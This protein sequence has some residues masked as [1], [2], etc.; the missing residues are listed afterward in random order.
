MRLPNTMIR[1]MN[2]NG[3]VRRSDLARSFCAWTASSRVTSTVP[4]TPVETIWPDVLYNGAS[5]AAI[6][7][8]ASSLPRNDATMSAWC[9][10]RLAS[11]AMSPRLQYDD[12]VTTPASRPRRWVSA[13]PAA[14]TAGAS[15]VPCFA[16]T[17][18]TK[19]DWPDDGNS[20]AMA[21]A[22]RLDSAPGSS[23][24]PVES[25]LCTPPPY[26]ANSGSAINATAITHHRRRITKIARRRTS[27]LCIRSVRA[28]DRSG[29]EIDFP[30]SAWKS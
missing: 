3:P 12:D 7:I 11:W 22:A 10:L 18:T 29:L 16:V 23:K 30:A 28:L 1:A 24:P 13:S 14:F 15:T 8:F 9:L 26:N 4:V 17:T 21:A 5:F 25:L 27:L 19:S 2:V 20:L 6:F